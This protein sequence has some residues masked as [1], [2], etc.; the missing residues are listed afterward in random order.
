M[1]LVLTLGALFFAIRSSASLVSLLLLGNAGVAQIFPGVVLGFYWRKVTTS[2]VFA[3]LATG[4]AVAV[5]LILTGR[6]PYRGLNAGFLA[7]C[8]NF[9]VTGAVS[10]FT[11][12]SIT[13]F[14]E[15]IPALATA[16]PAEQI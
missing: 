6:D 8:C 11:R 13:G 15:T 12:V 10:L 3:G 4:I 7:L 14:D 1:V 16:Q 5:F 2:G 9:A